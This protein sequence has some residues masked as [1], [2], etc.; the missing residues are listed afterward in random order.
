MYYLSR[1][2]LIA[3]LFG[4]L[5]ACAC[6]TRPAWLADLHLDVWSLP[7]ILDKWEEQKERK[8]Q[9]ASALKLARERTRLKEEATVGL[10]EGRLS[11]SEVSVLLRNLSDHIPAFED[12]LEQSW[13]MQSDS[14]RLARY[15]IQSVG[16]ALE[17]EPEKART[18]IARLE[19]E[20]TAMLRQ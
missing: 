20:L 11:L 16:W 13:P 7:D 19:R 6:H 8:H 1:L 12:Y 14:E 4:L 5:V 10:I 15:A 3:S 9:L 2:T 18:V 17:F